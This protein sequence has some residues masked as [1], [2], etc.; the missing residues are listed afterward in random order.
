MKELKLR[1]RVRFDREFITWP[2]AT[3]IVD[4]NQLLLDASLFGKY[5]FRPSDVISIEPISILPVLGQGIKINHKVAEY[6]KQM[7]FWT[8]KNPRSVISTIKQIGFLGHG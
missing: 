2:F 6:D 7:I 8:F 5:T 1:R 3:L 4:K